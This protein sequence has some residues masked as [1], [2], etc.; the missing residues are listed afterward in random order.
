MNTKPSP[1]GPV[2]VEIA[3]EIDEAE[4]ALKREIALALEGGD[5][6]RALYLVRRWG[7]VPAT[8]VLAEL[9]PE[10]AA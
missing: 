4:E 8:E 7:S 5:S 10:R 3:R 9:K 2:A 1:L 6:V